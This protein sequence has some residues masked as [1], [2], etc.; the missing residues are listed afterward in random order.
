MVNPPASPE[1]ALSD[2][3]TY[4]Q[5]KGA[6]KLRVRRSKDQGFVVMKDFRVCEAYWRISPRSAP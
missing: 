1:Q 6:K 5:E 2:A 4:M 3:G